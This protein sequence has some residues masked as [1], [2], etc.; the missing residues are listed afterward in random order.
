MASTARKSEGL[1]MS[2]LHTIRF[3]RE[4]VIGALP[5]CIR[6]ISVQTWIVFLL[7]E[8]AKAKIRKWALLEPC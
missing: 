1:S 5:T 7:T 8:L 3:L 2:E 6:V 4:R